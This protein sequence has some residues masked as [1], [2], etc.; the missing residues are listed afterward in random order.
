MRTHPTDLASL[1]WGIVLATITGLLA[2]LVFTDTTPALG[3]VLP[4]ALICAGT[5]VGVAAVLRRPTATD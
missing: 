4:A 1:A 2:V 5:L 3:L